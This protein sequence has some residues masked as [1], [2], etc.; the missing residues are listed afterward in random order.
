MIMG[1]ICT[2]WL[3]NKNDVCFP[4]QER[5]LEI[6]SLVE[7]HPESGSHGKGN[8]GPGIFDGQISHRSTVLW[9][10]NLLT[11]HVICF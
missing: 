7:N 5:I 4:S 6:T 9:A 8:L 10:C 11:Y 3:I 1:C 2:F